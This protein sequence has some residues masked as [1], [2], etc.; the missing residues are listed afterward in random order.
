MTRFRW[1]DWTIFVCVTLAVFF[2]LITA[3]NLVSEWLP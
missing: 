2:G 3:N 1:L